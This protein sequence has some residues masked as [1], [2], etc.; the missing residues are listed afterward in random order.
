MREEKTNFGH[1]KLLD[2]LRKKRKIDF[3]SLK[4]DSGPFDW[5]KHEEILPSRLPK[6][7]SSKSSNFGHFKLLDILDILRKKR[8]I[9]FFSF[10][11]DSGQ[12]NRL[13]WEDILPMR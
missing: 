13:K 8:K 11:T 2:I 4:S 10:K 1:F 5:L 12:Y 7:I 6:V 9:D 3:S